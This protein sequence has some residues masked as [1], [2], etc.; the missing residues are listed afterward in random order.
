[1]DTVV[2]DVAT[3]VRRAQMVSGRLSL[4]GF[5]N[6]RQGLGAVL[7]RF[8]CRLAF[9]HGVRALQRRSGA[10][11]PQWPAPIPLPIR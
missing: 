10:A 3:G 5:L 4:I 2:I 9:H 1:V 11:I 7:L 6:G 8:R